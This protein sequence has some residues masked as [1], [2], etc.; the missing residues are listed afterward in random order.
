MRKS[1]L[2]ILHLVMLLILLPISAYI[3]LYYWT[4]SSVEGLRKLPTLLWS[5]IICYILIQLVKGLITKR[6]KWF[7]YTYYLGLTVILFPFV[8]P[9]NPEWLLAVVRYGTIFLA[10]PPVMEL[11]RFSHNKI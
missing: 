1:I 5:S 8:F 9:A 11:I 3:L 7:E 2:R 10:F 6:V 4:N